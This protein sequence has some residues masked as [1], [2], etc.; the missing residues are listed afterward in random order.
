[1][2]K[3]KY[4]KIGCHASRSILSW[5]I[6]L[7]DLTDLQLLDK[8]SSLVHFGY[9]FSQAWFFGI[10]R[11]HFQ[12][13]LSK[14]EVSKRLWNVSYRLKTHNVLVPASNKI[15]ISR[16]TCTLVRFVQFYLD[17]MNSLALSSKI[18]KRFIAKWSLYKFQY[19]ANSQQ[20]TRWSPKKKRKG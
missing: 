3:A 16:K 2:T 1:M 15:A 5:A 9:F 17:S 7:P 6:I 13:H 8:V 11:Q 12:K 4:T 10:I 18:F 14:N 20:N 19:E